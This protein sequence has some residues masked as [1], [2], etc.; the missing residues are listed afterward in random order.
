MAYVAANRFSRVNAKVLILH[1]LEMGQVGFVEDALVDGFGHR[2]VDQFA[3]GTTLLI[4]IIFTL[5]VTTHHSNIPSWQ[6]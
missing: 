4:A 6:A 1:D 5:V 2:V 3:A